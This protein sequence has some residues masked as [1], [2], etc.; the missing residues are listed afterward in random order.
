MCRKPHRNEVKMLNVFL[1]DDEYFERTALKNHVPWAQN[2]FQVIGEAKDGK[3]AYR[4]ISELSPDIAIVDINIPGLN[5][6]E[7]IEKLC[8]DR[9]F[10]RYIILTGYDTFSYAQKALRLGVHDY[11]LKPINYGLFVQSLKE[12]AVWKAEPSPAGK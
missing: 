9:I 7:L 2:G 8:Q 1:V 11:I 4:M 6:L 5:G 12:Y 10:C 3:T